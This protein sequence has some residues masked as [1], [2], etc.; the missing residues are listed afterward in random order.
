MRSDGGEVD[1]IATG[2]SLGQGRGGSIEVV[3]ETRGIGV[4]LTVGKREKK[5]Q[6]GQMRERNRP[7]SRSTH[8]R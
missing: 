1:G 2:G 5:G 7:R 8:T 4:V 6:G 3:L